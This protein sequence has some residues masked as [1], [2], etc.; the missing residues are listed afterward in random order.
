MKIGIIGAGYVAQILG[1]RLVELKNE[2]MISS[3]DVN[4]EQAQGVPSAQHWM[5]TQ[6]KRGY[7]SNAGS[8]AQ[9][10]EFGEILFNCTS[11]DHSIEALK[12][13][14]LG[15]IGKKIL[16]DVANPLDTSR[17]M[18]PTLTIVNTTS[19]AEKIQDAF[20]GI[21][22]VKALNHITAEL[23]VNPKILSQDTDLLICGNDVNA[24]NWVKNELLMKWFGWKNVLDLGDI[25]AARGMEM[26]LTLWIRLWG[27]YKTPYINFHFIVKK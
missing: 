18:P 23:M 16:V 21:K 4:K 27:T 20:P 25:V 7:A 9:A 2:V 22:V 1:T 8:F 3:R 13:A 6:K 19:L 5:E 15:K 12:S 11:G 14:N 10:A 24:K 17:G 26:Y